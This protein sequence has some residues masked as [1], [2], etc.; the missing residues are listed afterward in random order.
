MTDPKRV[1]QQLRDLALCGLGAGLGFA[2]SA[3]LIKSANLALQ[4]PDPVLRALVC[5]VAINALQTLMQGPA[6]GSAAR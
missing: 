4:H 5:L 2:F 3:I 1:T 6:S